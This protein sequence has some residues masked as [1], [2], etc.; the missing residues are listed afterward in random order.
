[1]RIRTTVT[2]AVLLA[3][4]VGGCSSKP[5]YQEVVKQCTAA[6]KEKHKGG[7]TKKP[8]ECHDVKDDDYTALVAAQAVDDLGW[9]DSNGD[10]D[11]NK[12]LDSATEQ[13]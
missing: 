2:A 6:L 11:E 5:S 3:L 9:T 12:M 1:M 13:P 4:T 7:E 10:F 8:A